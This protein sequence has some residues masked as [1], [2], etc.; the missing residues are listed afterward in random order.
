MQALGAW[1]FPYSDSLYWLGPGP[2]WIG[3]IFLFCLPIEHLGAL[4]SLD[5][6]LLPCSKLYEPTPGYFSLLSEGSLL[7][8]PI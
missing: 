3:S 6:Y 2:G 8:F 7:A 1:K 4:V 5:E